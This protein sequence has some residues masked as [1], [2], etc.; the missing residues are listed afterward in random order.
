MHLFSV[1]C[2]FFFPFLQPRTYKQMMAHA[3]SLFARTTS[4]GQALLHHLL[5]ARNSTQKSLL[6]LVFNQTTHMTFQRDLVTP[7]IF[8]PDSLSCNNPG[9]NELYWLPPNGKQTNTLDVNWSCRP[10]ISH[11]TLIFQQ[12]KW[13]K[14]W[15]KLNW[16]WW[17]FSLS[18]II[19]F[20]CYD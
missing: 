6:V 10:V 4:Q 9:S 16:S 7:F 2:L 5:W 20:L 15:V 13:L 19:C 3:T 1:S 8:I 17:V 14:H 12:L 18:W 11:F